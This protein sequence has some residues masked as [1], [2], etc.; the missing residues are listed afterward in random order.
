MRHHDAAAAA[1]LAGMSLAFDEYGRPFII[2][3]E[4]EAKGRLKGLEAQKANIL[5]AKARRTLHA[6]RGAVTSR[7]LLLRH[8]R[9]FAALSPP[10]A[11]RAG[12]LQHPQDVARSQ[13]H[14]QDAAVAGRRRDDHQ[15]W[16][17]AVRREACGAGRGL[18]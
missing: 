2:I 11:A 14:G 18:R 15:R 3:K 16:R 13:G 1:R 9:R 17:G 6:R 7:R 8:P 5:A 4:G 12:R 10:P